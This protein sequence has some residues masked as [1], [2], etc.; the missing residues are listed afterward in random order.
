MK[1]PSWIWIKKE[2]YA[3]SHSNMPARELMFNPLRLKELRREAFAITNR[4]CK[5]FAMWSYLLQ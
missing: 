1:I 5:Y 2:I 3:L 4:S